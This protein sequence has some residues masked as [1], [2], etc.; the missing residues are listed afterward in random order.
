MSFVPQD[1]MQ[2][3]IFAVRNAT[4]GHQNN[5]S[6]IAGLVDHGTLQDSPL[7]SELGF[8]FENGKL[9]NKKV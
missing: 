3:A 4:N 5:Q 2:W 1:I 7:L 6:V 8:T 9:T